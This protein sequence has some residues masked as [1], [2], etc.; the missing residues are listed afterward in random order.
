M[1]KTVLR[2]GRRQCIAAFSFV[3]VNVALTM[4]GTCEGLDKS[5][6]DTRTPNK[7]ESESPS[8]VTRK[9]VAVLSAKEVP[10]DLTSQGL[11]IKIL[12]EAGFE[13]RAV[14]G[15]EVREKKLEG[16][17]IFI[18]GGGSGTTFNKSLGPEGGQAVQAFIRNGGGALASCAGGYSFVNGDTEVRRYVVIAQA[19]TIDTKDGRWARGKAEVEIAPEDDRYPPLKIFY[20]NGP[21]W[22]IAKE[23][24]VDR[25]VALARFKSDV[26]KEGDPGG[27]MPGTP[28]I[29]GGTCGKG[30]F[31]LFSGHPEFFKKMGNNSLVTDAARWV[32]RGPLK[33]EETI[34]WGD[35]FPSSKRLESATA[36]PVIDPDKAPGTAN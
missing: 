1:M 3:L 34:R 14:S 10:G 11:Y 16:F 9:R 18:I 20:Q 33:P 13:A 22:E 31:V 36:P 6:S 4:I 23:Q 35:V 19:K 28:A 24:G 15:E 5:D 2:R 8:Q 30:R 17:D 32:T 12:R 27:V 25:T 29:L 26:K 21:L 7:T